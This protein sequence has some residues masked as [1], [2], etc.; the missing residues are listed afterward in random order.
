[1]TAT[2]MPVVPGLPTGASRMYAIAFDLDTE[3]LQRTYGAP[4]C[5]DGHRSH[6][7]LV[8]D[9]GLR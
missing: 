1:M 3:T 4:S 9:A 6:D 8:G 2:M 7:R 5:L